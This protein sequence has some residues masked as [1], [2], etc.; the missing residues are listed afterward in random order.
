MGKKPYHKM[1]DDELRQAHLEWS[2]R[3]G[4]APGWSSAYFAAKQ[5][6]IICKEG[7]QRALGLVNEYPIMG[8]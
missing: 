3:V 5:V 8:G 4:D 6:E 7:K 2:A 1:T